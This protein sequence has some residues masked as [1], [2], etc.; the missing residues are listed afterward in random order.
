M[1]FAV[2]NPSYGIE[3]ADMNIAFIG[4][5][6][7]GWPMLA[8]LLK[9]GFSAIAYD[10][11]PAALD[12]AAALGAASS[13]EAAASGDMVITILPSS[14]NVE[15]AYLGAGGILEGVGRATCRAE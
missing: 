3:E 7:M 4:I 5:G 2:L 11:V 8:N 9:K 14:G 12:G 15:A 6:N 10:I 13:A 1:G